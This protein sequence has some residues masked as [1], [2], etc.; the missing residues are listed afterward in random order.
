MFKTYAKKYICIYVCVYR[1]RERVGETGVWEE[2]K[3]KWVKKAG[4]EGTWEKG[5]EV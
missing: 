5:E 1:E 3:K 4:R 2:G